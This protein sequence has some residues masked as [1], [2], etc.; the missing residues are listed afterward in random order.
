MESKIKLQLGAVDNLNEIK[1][2][3]INGVTREFL[4][5]L[6]Y[7]NLRKYNLEMDLK[8][9]VE[10]FVEITEA[11]YNHT[12]TEFLAWSIAQ[13]VII[14]DIME[15]ATRLDRF[16]SDNEKITQGELIAEFQSKLMNFLVNLNSVEITQEYIDLGNVDIKRDYIDTTLEELAI[17][18]EGKILSKLVE[19]RLEMS[20]LDTANKNSVVEKKLATVN[21]I[22]ESC[23]KLF[24]DD[25]E[26]IIDRI[27]DMNEKFYNICFESLTD[28]EKSE[29]ARRVIKQLSPHRELMDKLEDKLSEASELC[30][31]LLIYKK[32]FEDSVDANLI[33]AENRKKESNQSAEMID[34]ETNS[35]NFFAVEYVHKVEDTIV[36]LDAMKEKISEH[37]NV[38]D[39]L[40][41]ALKSA[42]PAESDMNKYSALPHKLQEI[43]V[44]L[45]MSKQNL[46]G[47]K[48]TLKLI[49]TAKIGLKTMITYAKT[50]K[51][52]YLRNS[53]MTSAFKAVNAMFDY[54][55]GSK[56]LVVIR[57]ITDKINEHTEMYNTFN[58]G[59]IEYRKIG[60]NAI[61]D[62]SITL[63]KQV[64]GVNLLE[65]MEIINNCVSRVDTLLD[66]LSIN[67]DK[68]NDLLKTILNM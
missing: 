66:S 55:N 29:K 25:K 65:V 24:D 1:S 49:E 41:V 48:Q 57:A 63:G 47:D 53:L 56:D 64:N 11:N 34:F 7:S 61:R 51:D 42:V 16:L 22:V 2:S 30:R 17:V 38:L 19:M 67:N 44:R 50:A 46:K 23:E 68:Q 62:I 10:E 9:Q 60:N 15:Y 13:S 27:L 59:M 3:I 58:D 26:K 35:S 31:Q 21:R 37:Y 40:E 14:S 33:D 4:I 43:S 20:P 54:V 45:D 39:R 32:K 18:N 36:R 52:L 8:T 5:D 6:V 12:Y 28:G